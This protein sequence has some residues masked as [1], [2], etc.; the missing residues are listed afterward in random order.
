MAMALQ[1]VAQVQHFRPQVRGFPLHPVADWYCIYWTSPGDL[2][3]AGLG[4]YGS[5]VQGVWVAHQRKHTKRRKQ[6]QQIQPH[7]IIEVHCKSPVVLGQLQGVQPWPRCSMGLA[8]RSST[9]S[10]SDKDSAGQGSADEGHAGLCVERV[11]LLQSQR[12][13]Y[14]ETKGSA[15]HA[16][17]DD[18]LGATRLAPGKLYE[19]VSSSAVPTMVTQFAMLGPRSQGCCSE[20]WRGSWRHPRLMHGPSF[21]SY[22]RDTPW[23]AAGSPF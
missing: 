12:D 1:M 17:A 16:I 2:L 15:G 19:L 18:A 22:V 11:A 7:A 21:A 20:S 6:A 14:R 5:P 3:G 8:G 13:I 4:K 10:R 9:V 23:C